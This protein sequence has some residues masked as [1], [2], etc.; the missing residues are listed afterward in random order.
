MSSSNP[1]TA[2]VLVREHPFE[3]AGLGRAPFRCVGVYQIPS[4][5]LAAQNPD[6]YNNALRMMPRGYGCGTCNFCGQAIM[7]CY[8][9]NSADG[10]KFAVGC[11]CVEKTADGPLITKVEAER[12]R[13]ERERRQA[14]AA[15]KREVWLSE[16]RAKAE[17]ARA[18]QDAREAAEAAKREAARAGC[19]AANLWLI[20]VLRKHATY[21]SFCENIARDLETRTIAEMAFTPRAISI[22]R[23]IYAKDA[24]RRGSKAFAAAAAAFDAEVSQ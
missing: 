23:D 12:R 6:A 7:N 16:R 10:R 1:Q 18:E 21:S 5:A 17:A 11:D 2:E 22:L 8:L 24:G 3:L 20:T 9:I 15:A 14:A 13:I 19:T 4:Q